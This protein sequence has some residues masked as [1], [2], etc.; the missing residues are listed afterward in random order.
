MSPRAHDLMYHQSVKS[1]PT[2]YKLF[3]QAHAWEGGFFLL[4]Q[5][6]GSFPTPL[7]G[8]QPYSLGCS[9]RAVPRKRVTKSSSVASLARRFSIYVCDDGVGRRA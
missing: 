8:T 9:T 4:L 1:N 3:L 7:G 5:D 6:V 2:L